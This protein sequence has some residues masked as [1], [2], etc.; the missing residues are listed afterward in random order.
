MP[1]AMHRKRVVATDNERFDLII[2]YSILSVG[3]EQGMGLRFIECSDQYGESIQMEQTMADDFNPP[4][5]IS[6]KCGP[7]ILLHGLRSG[8]FCSSIFMGHACPQL[9]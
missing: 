5:R 4:V 3:N 8:L 9:F 6:L 7:R 2:V 1:L